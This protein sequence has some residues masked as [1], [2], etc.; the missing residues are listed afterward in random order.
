MTY[1]WRLLTP[2]LAAIAL[3]QSTST[4]Q[5][6][7]TVTRLPEAS[8]QEAALAAHDGRPV[9]PSLARILE[10]SKLPRRPPNSLSRRLV[11]VTRDA[12]GVQWGL[13]RSTAVTGY[14][15]AWLIKWQDG[16]WAEPL[17]LQQG[18]G[19][20]GRVDLVVSASTAT[21]VRRYRSILVPPGEENPLRVQRWQ[22]TLGPLRKDADKDGFTDELESRLGTDPDQRDT[23][24]DGLI[25]SRDP[26][27]L[28][29]P[30][31]LDL[32]DQLLAAA[33]AALRRALPATGP[34]GL[35]LPPG[36]RP[37]EFPGYTWISLPVIQHHGGVGQTVNGAFIRTW[38]S[39]RAPLPPR[40]GNAIPKLPRPDDPVVRWGPNRTSA[41]TFI[42][43]HQTHSVQG[44]Q[45]ELRRHQGRWV[46]DSIRLQLIS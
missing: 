27:P 38:V 18:I 11:A 36:T 26:N 29:A 15:D 32:K 28:V 39:F 46:V 10:L 20:Y 5:G 44:Y 33:Y 22:A 4:G 6:H 42:V 21:V 9:L 13:L 40:I 43:E 23:D 31:R 24:G 17:L 2:L 35:A 12:D 41:S 8:L 30:R 37:M 45:V 14:A 25:D 1:S 19:S 34:V 7:V 3:T 16:R